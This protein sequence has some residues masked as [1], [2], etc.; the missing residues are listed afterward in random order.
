[1]IIKE[2]V[3]QVT[4]VGEDTSKKAKIS[5]DKLGKLQYLLT[6]GLY[7]DPITAVI[8]EWTNNG[9]DSVVQAGK[10]PIQT[11]V[12]VKI[13]RNDKG[14]M[15]LSVEDEGVGLDDKDFE[16][17]CMNYLESTKEGDND[18]IGHFGIGMKSF[19]S[20]E[21]SA[22]FICR[23]NGIERKYLVYEGEEFVNYDLI[24]EAP[25]DKSNGVIA[26]IMITDWNE[27]SNFIS[28]AKQKLA[29]Y[30]T[31]VLIVDNNI[32]QNKITRS[33]DFQFSDMNTNQ[34]IH[35]CLKDVYYTI[36]W[37]ALGIRNPIPIPIALRFHLK[38]GLTPTPSRESYITNE[39]TKKLILDKIG[40]VAEWF[41][42]KYN[43]TVLE[44]PSFIDGFEYIG[45]TQYNVMNFNINPLINY[46]KT[47]PL[48]P[49]VKGIS[50][51]SPEFYKINKDNFFTEYELAGY[52]TYNGQLKRNGQRLYLDKANHVLRDKKKSVLVGS[53]FVGN[54]KEFLK[55]KYKPE[56]LFLRRNSFVRKI[57]DNT[58]NQNFQCYFSILNLSMVH[59]DNWQKRIDEFNHVQSTI[60][61]TFDDQTQVAS[62]K[63]YI[64][65]IDKKKEDQRQKRLAN[66]AKG[67]YSGLNKQQGDITLA[68]NYDSLRGVSFKK[69]AVPISTLVGNQFLTVL[70]EEDYPNMEML[71]A[72]IK[73]MKCDKIKFATAGKKEMKKIPDHY[74]FINISK[75]MTRD[76]KP[77]M[78]LASA[79]LYK[80]LLEDLTAVKS[81]RG[82]LF[83]KFVKHLDSDEKLL[84]D[85][86]NKN[87]TGHIDDKAQQYIKDAAEQNKLYDLSLWDS[88]LR[89]KDNIKKYDFINLLTVPNSWD[90]E[91]EKQYNTLITQILYFRKKYY[92]DL[93]EGAKVVFQ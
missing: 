28:K 82:G 73:V 9:I 92:N 74:Q 5:Q 56:T 77:F 64:D 61:S 80:G 62:S 45:N 31:A 2:Q 7:K 90:K 63:E 40:K 15:F 52:I 38:D 67:V 69:K 41:V 21:R 26:E 29:Y 1:M 36:D 75:F 23:K 4:V 16:D 53:D 81:S 88:Y 34:N 18:T 8:A 51:L 83:S 71:K 24:H 3:K 60:I 87:Y 10:D 50:V 91:K 42:K 93:P 35:L 14:Q 72:I 49:K 37:D 43:D 48:T 25:T 85:Y 55:T 27:R 19:L 86:V 13:G 33:D 17:I 66:A 6:K 47:K 20:L 39:K 89:V 12:I 32:V 65:W 79:I 57:G 30:D 76:C 11:P 22:T 68:Y 58:D 46:A 78:R 44:F 54:V 84:R 59:K 70:I